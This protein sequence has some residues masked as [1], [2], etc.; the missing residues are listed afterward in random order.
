[1]TVFDLTGQK[2]NKQ[3]TPIQLGANQWERKI[4]IKGSEITAL[5]TTASDVFKVLN[6]GQ[7]VMVN[8]MATIVTDADDTS[9]T[10]KIGYTDG[11]NTDEDAYDADVALDSTGIT[12]L[13]NNDFTA[14]VLLIDEA[15]GADFFL[16]LTFSA[17]STLDDATEFIILVKGSSFND[18][19]YATTLNAPV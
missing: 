13:G 10:L 15:V 8:E 18:V 11:T 19:P 14:N 9:I 1:M 3:S 16:T 4:V 5:S 17:L 2:Y 12:A 7:N 6:L